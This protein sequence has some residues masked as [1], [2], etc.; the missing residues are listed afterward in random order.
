MLARIAADAVLVTH[1]AFVLFVLLGGLLVLR[2][3][4]LAWLHLPAVVWGALIELNGWICPLTPLEV[5]LRE[6]AGGTG[7]RGDFLQH[8]I[9]ALLYPEGL[10]RTMQ[11]GF[12]GLV[13]LINTAIYVVILRRPRA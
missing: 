11:L 1:L 4:K 5:A 2:W 8:Y 6:A 13:L 9:V 12:G 10:T 7:Y 3:P